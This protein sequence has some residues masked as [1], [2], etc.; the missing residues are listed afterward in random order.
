ME[1]CLAAGSEDSE[2]VNEVIL[3][4]EIP[5]KKETVLIFL[6]NFFRKKKIL[7]TLW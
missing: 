7:Y 3:H 6:K 1:Q 2:E 5:W 4:Q